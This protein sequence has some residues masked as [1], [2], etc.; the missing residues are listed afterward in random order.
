MPKPTATNGVIR[1]LGLRTDTQAKDNPKSGASNGDKLVDNSKVT[2][3]EKSKSSNTVYREQKAGTSTE[4]SDGKKIDGA[5][6]QQNAEKPTIIR[7]T[8]PWKLSNFMPYTQV[9]RG[10]LQNCEIF[11]FQ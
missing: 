8:G 7:K 4:N 11:I 1:T 2:N 10:K 5:P 6:A 9:G 3:E